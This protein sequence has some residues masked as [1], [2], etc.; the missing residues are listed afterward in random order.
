MQTSGLKLRKTIQKL[1][2]LLTCV[3]QICKSNAA[4]VEKKNGRTCE[5]LRLSR[6]HTGVARYLGTIGVDDSHYCGL[7]ALRH[8]RC[9]TAYMTER[10]DRLFAAIVADFEI[11]NR[12]A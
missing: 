10:P 3:A 12:K 9:S 8:R 11:V 4:L 2:N 7:R 5:H 6:L 1:E